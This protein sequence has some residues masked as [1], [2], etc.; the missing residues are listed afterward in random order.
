MKGE[1]E[2]CKDQRAEEPGQLRIP[3]PGKR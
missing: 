1:K 3:A 2:V